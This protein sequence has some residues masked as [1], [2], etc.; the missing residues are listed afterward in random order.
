MAIKWGSV[1]VTPLGYVY[2]QSEGKAYTTEQIDLMLLAAFL[3]KP[4]ERGEL[5]ASHDAPVVALR[6][7]TK[8]SQALNAP[9]NSYAAEPHTTE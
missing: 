5:A 6:D 8:D 4:R 9:G 1:R 7:E 2:P 3:S